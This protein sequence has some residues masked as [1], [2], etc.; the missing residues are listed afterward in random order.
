MTRWRMWT[1]GLGSINVWATFDLFPDMSFYLETIGA[2]EYPLIGVIIFKCPE[3]I[4]LF[5]IRFGV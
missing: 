4:T 1:L 5:R 2:K 3:D